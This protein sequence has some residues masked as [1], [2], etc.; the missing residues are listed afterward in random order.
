M[1]RR[2]LVALLAIVPLGCNAVLGIEQPILAEVDGGAPV[3]AAPATSTS[4]I[5]TLRQPGAKRDA[6][7]AGERVTIA[8]AV[9]TNVKTIGTS[10]LLFVQ[11][12]TATVWG[13]IEIFVGPS[14]P[15]VARGDVVTATGTVRIFHGLDN[16]D[17]TAGSYAK[18]GT[19]S[20]P[21]PIDVD[22]SDLNA[23]GPRRLELQAML[24]RVKNIK[25][26]VGSG[27]GGL[28]KYEFMVA[29]ETNPGGPA[30]DVTCFYMGDT[31]D[32]VA[33]TSTQDQA[34][35]S[36]TGNAVMS[37]PG[38]QDPTGKLA[39]G[40]PGDVVLKCRS[41]AARPPWSQP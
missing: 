30:L 23:Q 25:T 28:P 36:I 16:L 11:D 27:T 4:S 21:T 38:T 32:P 35:A 15:T 41:R 5:A 29:A 9:V 26:T 33:I 40:S 10:K 31:L 17:V 24:V 3:D 37:A 19:A 14:D 18:T 34:Y 7:L 13:G 2:W 20:I 12:P 8:G 6:A 1:V 39:P 22:V